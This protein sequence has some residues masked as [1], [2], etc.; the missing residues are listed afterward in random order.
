MATNQGQLQAAVRTAA[1]VATGAYNENW[2]DLA[3]DQG[4]SGTYNERLIQYLQNDL[5]SAATNL[6]GLKAAKAASLSKSRWGD[7]TALS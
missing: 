3:A 1:S 4:Y 7:L 2:A 6:P 5:S